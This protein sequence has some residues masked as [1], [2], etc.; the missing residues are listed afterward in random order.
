MIQSPVYAGI[1]LGGTN[2]RVGVFDLQG[3]LFHTEFE[4]VQAANGPRKC[5]DRVGELVNSC[6]HESKGKLMGI[7]IG[8]SGPVNPK[9]GTIHNPFTLPGWADVPVVMML[10]DIF[11]VPVCLENDADMA[12]LGEY[13][14]GAGKGINR[15]FSVTF[16]TGIGTSF[17]YR[18]EVYRGLDGNHP[19]GGHHSIDP[20]GPICYCGIRGCWEALASGSAIGRAGREMAALH[21]ESLMVSI[22]NGDL[23]AIDGEVV[24]NAARNGDASALEV[25]HRTARYM[26]LGLVNINS[27]FLPEVIV[28]SGGVMRDED[29]FLPIMQQ[30]II[31]QNVM[32]PVDQVRIVPASL[33]YLSGIYGSAYAIIHHAEVL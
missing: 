6:L 26:G 30:T 9:L 4:L 33:G 15:L 32:L 2:V 7:G 13:W 17:I 3:R 19:E 10:R 31:E 12:A 21:P 27:L 16:G 18:G 22:S 11:N 20:A 5:I 25:I 24:V 28:L 29:L 8:A 1:D 14:M 23:D